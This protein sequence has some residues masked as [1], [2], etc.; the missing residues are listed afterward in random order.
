M[1]SL[2]KA[3]AG[4]AMGAATLVGVPSLFI[5]LPCWIG[6]QVAEAFGWNPGITALLF[7]FGTIGG[8]VGLL[9]ATTAEDGRR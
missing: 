5:L 3:L 6:M 9:G 2:G 1:A 8:F 4:A 7:T